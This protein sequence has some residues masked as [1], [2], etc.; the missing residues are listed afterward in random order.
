MACGACAQAAVS[1]TGRRN[2]YPESCGASPIA[3]TPKERLRFVT[4]KENIMD[5]P[6]SP[7]EAAHLRAATTDPIGTLDDVMGELAGL[8]AAAATG[9]SH[10]RFSQDRMSG[11][12]TSWQRNEPV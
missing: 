11:G 4:L 5:T 6:L 8:R 12:G 10:S 9:R 3:Y 1:A 2:R 7:A